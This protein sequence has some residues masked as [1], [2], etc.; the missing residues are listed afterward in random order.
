[1]GWS[2][3]Q[4]L[5]GGD[6]INKAID[7]GK[8]VVNGA[9]RAINDGLHSAGWITKEQRD[10][11]SKVLDGIDTGLGYA[12]KAVKPISDGLNFVSDVKSAL[13]PRREKPAQ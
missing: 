13:A 4:N 7:I 1:M 5:F 8:T 2:W 11:G 9:G 3:L 12:D 6:A 10:T